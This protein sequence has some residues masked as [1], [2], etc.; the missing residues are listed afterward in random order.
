MEKNIEAF[1][2]NATEVKNDVFDIDSVIDQSGDFK[3]MFGIDVIVKSMLRSLLIIRGTYFLDKDFGTTL[4]LYLFEPSDENTK[5]KIEAEVSRVI[6][7]YQSGAKVTKKIQFFKN[8]KGFLI[9][10][11]ISYKGQTREVSIPIDESLLKT[12]EK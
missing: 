10:L 2:K 3:L 5:E 12:L 4:Y 7:R 8:K 11:Y 6:S 9:D 1:F